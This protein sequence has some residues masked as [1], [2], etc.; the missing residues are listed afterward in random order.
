MCHDV[1]RKM[2]YRRGRGVAGVHRGRRKVAADGLA[3]ASNY[4][5][6]G[7][8]FVRG[9]WGT[10]RGSRGLDIGARGWRF[11]ALMRGLKRGV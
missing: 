6:P 7:G 4:G 10:E 8:E 11:F 9:S 5:Q 1:G 2:E 3:P